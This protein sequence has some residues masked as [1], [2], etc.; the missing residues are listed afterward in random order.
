M[1]IKDLFNNFFLMEDEEE[2]E[3]PAERQQRVT[4]NEENQNR[5]MQQQPIERTQN[6]QNHLKTVP[7][8]KVSKNY[9]TEERNY[10]M[11]HT[12]NKSNSKNVV[13]MNQSAGTGYSNYENSKMCLFEPRVFSDTQDIADELKNRRATLVNLQ[14]IDKVSAKRII[15]FLS[16]TVYAI[17][18]DIQ[19]V[20]AD[21]FLCTPD[22]V[23]VAGSITDHLEQMNTQQHYE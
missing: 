19:R 13:T 20:G 10:R 1:A 9:N 12:S 8:K 15:D 4:Q 22:N 3:S 11:G 17:G 5:N 6:N 23:E 18:G 2:V 14:R 21:I 16:G 7:Q